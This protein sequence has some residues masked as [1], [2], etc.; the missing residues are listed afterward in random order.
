MPQVNPSTS[1]PKIVSNPLRLSWRN[2]ILGLFIGTTLIGGGLV[3]YYYFELKSVSSSPKNEQTLT[4]KPKETSPSATPAQPRIITDEIDDWK[5]YTNSKRGYSFRYPESYRLKETQASTT[6]MEGICLVK[7]AEYAVGQGFMGS[8]VLVKGVEICFII[9]PNGKDLSESVLKNELGTNIDFR[10]I[11]VDRKEGLEIILPD[12]IDR[13]I[14]I[15]YNN[16]VLSINTDAQSSNPQENK[17]YLKD[18]S[19]I[20]STFKFLSSTSSE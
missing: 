18:F 15:K 17:G 6:T 20:L 1:A 11:K 14:Y 7:D 13:I 4:G 3:A 5:T 2:V 10:T 12:Q 16:I 8:D 9:Y 19:E